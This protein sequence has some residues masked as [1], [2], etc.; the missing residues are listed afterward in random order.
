MRINVLKLTGMSYAERKT[1]ITPRLAH[2]ARS[3][4]VKTRSKYLR[5]SPRIAPPSLASSHHSTIL[6]QKA[7]KS[8][9]RRDTIP[10][11]RIAAARGG[12]CV[13]SNLMSKEPAT[14][15]KR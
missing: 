2:Q 14:P 5:G 6:G 9:K 1:A 3:E 10:S 11:T 12:E 8:R 13:N 7:R 4:G 15:R